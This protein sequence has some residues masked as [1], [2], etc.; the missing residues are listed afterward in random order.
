MYIIQVYIRTLNSYHIT[1]VCNIF[2]TDVL[3]PPVLHATYKN[4]SN[5]IIVSWSPV[6]SGTICTNISIS[7]RGTI[8]PTHGRYTRVNDTAYK[9][10]RLHRNTTYTITVYA[11]I[12]RRGITGEPATVTVRTKS[13]S[14]TMYKYIM[15]NTGILYL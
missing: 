8:M 4:S 7:Y 2:L 5:E 10:T 14:G 6:N 9:F 3:K 12:I 11:T 13:L 15:H 1:I